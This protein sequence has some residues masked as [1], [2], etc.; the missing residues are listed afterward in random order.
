MAQANGTAVIEEETIILQRSKQLPRRAQMI[1]TRCKLNQRQTSNPMQLP[2]RM[3]QMLPITI[4]TRQKTSPILQIKHQLQR[5]NSSINQGIIRRRPKSNQMQR[6]K[7]RQRKQM[8]NPA[9]H[10][11]METIRNLRLSEIIA[12]KGALP[13][14]RGV[15]R[16]KTLRIDRKAALRQREILRTRL[17]HKRIRRALHQKSYRIQN[18]KYWS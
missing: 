18:P 17:S 12:I 1:Q 11:P 16:G 13:T 4:K 3:S 8:Y 2:T 7:L 10:R 5:R 15:I 6:M 9:A 14:K